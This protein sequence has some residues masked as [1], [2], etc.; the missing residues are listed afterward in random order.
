MEG[1]K[2]DGLMGVNGREKI[3]YTW[4]FKAWFKVWLGMASSMARHGSLIDQA[5]H[6]EHMGHGRF[7]PR[8]GQPRGGL[9]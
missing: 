3:S 6:E 4:S 7:R 5:H 8:A 9:V 1:M 2:A